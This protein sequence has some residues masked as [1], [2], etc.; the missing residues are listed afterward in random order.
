MELI[1][2][3]GSFPFLYPDEV[4]YSGIARCHQRTAG[5]SFKGTIRELYEGVLVGGTVDLPSYLG[6]LAKALGDPL[7][8]D[9]LIEL[10]TLLPYYRPFL[11]E[12]R[13]SRA[14]SLMEVGSR[15]G[16][17]H[18]VVGLLASGVKL[19]SFLRYCPECY[20]EDERIHGT[21]YWHRVH[22]LPGVLVC[23]THDVYLTESKVRFNTN[24]HKH[25][26]TT[27]S[28]IPVVYAA[29]NVPLSENEMG[30]LHFIAKQSLALLNSSQ[31]EVNAASIRQKYLRKLWKLGYLTSS[32]RFIM[33][34]LI[35]DYKESTADI[36]LEMAGEKFDNPSKETWLHRLTRNPSKCSHP[37][38]HLAVL[39]FLEEDVQFLLNGEQTSVSHIK[40]AVHTNNLEHSIEELNIRRNRMLGTISTLNGCSRKEI[41][42]NNQKDFTWL[43]RHDRVWLMDVLPSSIIRRNNHVRRINWGRRDD[44]LVQLVGTA[45]TD[46]FNSELPVR[47]SSAAVGRHINQRKLIDKN[48]DKLPR[49]RLLLN[50]HLETTE[51]FQIRRLE[52]AFQSLME[53]EGRAIGWRLL[54]KA[55]IPDHVSEKVSIRGKELLKRHDDFF[56]SKL[57]MS[58][59]KGVVKVNHDRK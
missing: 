23:P 50:S 29:P 35:A 16:E 7:L 25:E 6:R 48:L 10:H 2:L 34:N 21:P 38:R 20:K 33:R 52:W 15:W 45:I 4:L 32:E 37:L 17:V 41:R 30:Q 53:E 8:T 13:Y 58:A 5:S 12:E 56:I 39:R 42:L 40:H 3:L 46:L 26:F 31:L 57:S 14:R 54:R 51:Q 43:Y 18:S 44:E 19:P 1:L 24:D 36:L 55:G 22:Q 47:I 9:Q 27:L 28:S 11:T 59:I 49:T